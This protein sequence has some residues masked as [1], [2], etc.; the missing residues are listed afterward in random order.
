MDIYQAGIVSISNNS[1]VLNG[2]G[3]RWLNYVGVNDLVF[4]NGKQLLIESVNDNNLIIL[5][6]FF[7]G[8]SITN[9][10]YYIDLSSSNLKR[11]KIL[12][13]NEIDSFFVQFSQSDIEYSGSLYSCNVQ[14]QQNIQGKILELESRLALSL[15]SIPMFWYDINGNAKSFSTIQE[16]LTWL[17]QLAVLIAERSTNLFISTKQLKDQVNLLSDLQSVQSFQISL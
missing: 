14:A 3:T 15:P 17:Q 2:H 8:P 16:H 7:E 1:N 10:N 6:S 12:K 13:N 5:S 11:A 4:L 9:S